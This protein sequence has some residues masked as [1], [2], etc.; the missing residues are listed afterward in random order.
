MMLHKSDDS[1]ARG[2]KLGMETALAVIE[3]AGLTESELRN[4]K[5]DA[6]IALLKAAEHD[7]EDGS[8]SEAGASPLE[9]THQELQTAK[10]RV[11]QA[12]QVALMGDDAA[13]EE[14]G[15]G[16][17]GEDVEEIRLRARNS[18]IQIF[19]SESPKGSV[20]LSTLVADAGSTEDSLHNVKLQAQRAM[21][22]SF[23]SSL[24]YKG[25]IVSEDP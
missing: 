17:H 21:E 16:S 6:E 18:M 2:M 19:S 20:S 5:A 12:L 24:T 23:S 11:K 15:D 9:Y 7:T 4:I 13:E 1:Y 10:G 3:K 8:D 25:G 14:G 22:D